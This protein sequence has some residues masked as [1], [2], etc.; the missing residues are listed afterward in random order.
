MKKMTFLVLGLF[1][2]L[3][4]SSVVAYDNLY[5]VGNASPAGWNTV[6][7]VQNTMTNE[8]GGIFTWTGTLLSKDAGD[9]G[10]M[11]FKFRINAG[12]WDPSLTCTASPSGNRLVN[13]G[14]EYELRERAGGDPDNAFQVAET[15]TYI[16]TINTNTMKMV[17]QKEGSSVPGVDNL[18][19]VG[20]ASYAEW[21]PGKSHGMTKVSD[22][23][24]TW[25]GILLCKGFASDG[26]ARFK[27]LVAK[28]WH[29]SYTCQIANPGHTLVTPGED[30]DLYKRENG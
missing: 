28:D 2:I 16:I 17:I 30:Y 27:F 10:Q 12:L 1:L 8:G 6:E 19:I 4:T 25:T 21:D 23:V 18:Y 15:G 11:R 20:S 5:L 7:N 14:E 9:G 22:G 24:F 26:N 29:P 13:P 3:G